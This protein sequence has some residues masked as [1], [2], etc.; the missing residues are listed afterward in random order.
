MSEIARLIDQAIRESI[1]PTLKTHGFRKDGRNFRR[2]EP[3]CIWIVNVQASAWNSNEEGRF[4]IN[5]GVHFPTLVP[6]FPWKK[7]TDRPS[8]V[9]C[10]VRS[11]IGEL[12]WKVSPTTNPDDLKADISPRLLQF[13]LPWFE[14]HSNLH[15][16]RNWVLAQ[17]HFPHWY[18]AAI[19]L[20]LNERDRALEEVQKSLAK[21]RG[22][23]GPT[24]MIPWGQQHGLLPKG[25][26]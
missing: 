11:R 24:T 2:R 13:A 4:T 1:A 15:E 19:S 23:P 6:Y 10:L 25:L 8:E 3:N 7:D 17:H 18:A 12:W 26:S 9:R 20:A 22:E 5:L 16:A 14:K 21:R